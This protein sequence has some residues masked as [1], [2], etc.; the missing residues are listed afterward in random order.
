MSIIYLETCPPPHS[1]VLRYS[2]EP[3]QFPHF[4]SYTTINT[5]LY[6]HNNR[7]GYYLLLL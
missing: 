5:N 2:F 1:L 4:F 6:T 3:F 7:C